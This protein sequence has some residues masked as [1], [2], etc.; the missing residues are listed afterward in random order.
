MLHMVGAGVYIGLA[1]ETY[2]RLRWKKKQQLITLI[3]DLFFWLLNVICIF[4]WLH[5]VNQGEMRIYV[6]LSLLCGYAMYKALLQQMYRNILE[7]I[8]RSVIYLYRLVVRM[9]R[10]F[11]IQPIVWLYKLIIALIFFIFGLLTKMVQ[12]LYSILLFLA[13]PF[14]RLYHYVKKKMVQK[15]KEYQNKKSLKKQTQKKGILKWVANWLF[16]KKS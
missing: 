13:R 1:Y 11:I 6:I 9:I 4:L 15:R 16:K 7:K 10:L 14:I 3:Q 5:Y 12:L 2:S 8:I